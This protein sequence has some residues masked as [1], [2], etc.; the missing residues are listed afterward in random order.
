MGINYDPLYRRII[1]FKYTSWK[2]YTVNIKNYLHEEIF[3]N[4]SRIKIFIRH[5]EDDDYL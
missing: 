4:L 1:T 5:A 2:S 3:V